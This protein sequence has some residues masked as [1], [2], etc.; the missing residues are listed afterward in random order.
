MYARVV[1]LV[2]LLFIVPSANIAQAS[3]ISYGYKLFYNGKYDKVDGDHQIQVADG[4]CLSTFETFIDRICFEMNLGFRFSK[5]ALDL[6]PQVVFH[7]LRFQ[8]LIYGWF[9]SIGNSFSVLQHFQAGVRVATGFYMY[10]VAPTIEFQ[11]AIDTRGQV[12]MRLFFGLTVIVP[13]G[14]INFLSGQGGF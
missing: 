3:G 12:D 2:S 10:F 4:Y 1:L 14:S 5:L 6:N 9:F 11:T 13:T 8:P 7:V